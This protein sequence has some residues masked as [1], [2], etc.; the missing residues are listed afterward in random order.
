MKRKKHL[1]ED[2]I[3]LRAL[4]VGFSVYLFG[5]LGVGWANDWPEDGWF[6]AVTL[7]LSVIAGILCALACAAF[8]ER[9]NPRARNQGGVIQ[10]PAG[11]L[12]VPAG[13]WIQNVTFSTNST[14]TNP[15]SVEPTEPFDADEVSQEEPIIAWRRWDYN[16]GTLYGMTESPWPG[17]FYAAGCLD[18]PPP[19]W[20]CRC[21]VNACK[22]EGIFGRLG[23]PFPG[24]V[25]GRVELMGDVHEYEHAYRASHANIIELIY[26]TEGTGQRT[27]EVEALSQKYG[28]PVFEKEVQEFITQIETIGAADGRW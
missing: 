11:Q 26:I 24:A 8:L 6:L 15:W 4:I 13:T 5:S 18:H 14:N 28:V 3:T 10:L 1:S 20:S 25:Y 27:D 22:E 23:Y 9:T 17:R 7:V 16:D 12:S 2:Q 21:G 19:D